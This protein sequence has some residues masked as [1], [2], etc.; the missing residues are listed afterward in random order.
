MS[1]QC[2]AEITENL[3]QCVLEVTLATIDIVTN[4]K[5]STL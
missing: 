5:E 3:V 1:D 4:Q 2:L